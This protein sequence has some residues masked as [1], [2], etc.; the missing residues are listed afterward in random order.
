MPRA[1]TMASPIWGDDHVI[2]TSSAYESGSRA[3]KLSEADDK[4]TPEELWYT[5]K[6]RVHF[7]S[8]IRLGDYVYASSGQDGPA[9]LSCINVHTGKVK[10]RERG[11][12][13]SS[14]CYADDKIIFLDED[15][16]LGLAKVSPE[17]MDVLSQCRISEARCWSAPTIVGTTMYV[18]DRQDIMALDLSA[19]SGEAT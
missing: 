17:G 8:S 13:K 18:R 5:R 1:S 3:I 7:G 16:Q 10:W 19:G 11:F 4:I 12:A 2:F 6:I 14:L 15:G 9:F